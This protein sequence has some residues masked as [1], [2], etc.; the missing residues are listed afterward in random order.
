MSDRIPVKEKAE[1]PLRSVQVAEAVEG[2][3]V[4]R[5]QGKRMLRGMLLKALCCGAPLLLV[6]AISFFG[7]SLSGVL[8]PLLI[9]VAM[10]ACPLGTY[11]MMRTMH[12]K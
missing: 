11:F 3:G 5:P 6:L 4:A 2:V 10:L 1:S 12:K 8:W 9:L 7:I